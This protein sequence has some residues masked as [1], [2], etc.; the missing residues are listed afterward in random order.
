MSDRDEQRATFDVENSGGRR[1]LILRGSLVVAS[2]A[3]LWEPV[4]AA[5]REGDSIEVDAS[6]VDHCDGAGLALLAALSG[7]S[8]S[9]ELTGLSDSVARRLKLHDPDALAKPSES[10]KPDSIPVRVGKFTVQL[11]RSLAEQVEFVGRVV[12]VGTRSLLQ[13]A[14]IRWADVGIAAERA[15]ANAVP[16]VTIIGFLMG[17][18]MAFQSALPMQQFGVEIF[19]AD[20]V[21]IS[22]LK[23]LG[24]LMAAVVLAGRT[25]S[26]FAAELGTM[27]VNDEINALETMGVDPV[28]FLVIPRVL[29]A[30]LISPF[31]G[32]VC[33]AAGL[34]GGAVV[35]LSL[36]YPLATYADRVIA[37]VTLGAFLGG[38]VKS[39]AFG[40]LVAAV[41]CLRGLETGRDASA[42]GVSAT[43]AV[44]S[45]IVLIAV[46]DAVFAVVFYVLDI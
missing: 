16:I 36:G 32:L 12:A 7:A 24:P 10:S 8:D 31:L 29:G 5:A 14:K 40:V 1:R 19:V 17:L 9:V 43:R 22:M 28:R 33:S 4:V 13:P 21:A 23:E 45:G 26:A 39:V 15:G 2:V 46:S 3:S 18:I 37:T 38:V 27:T 35:L 30:V 34:F 44:V 42:V 41:G 6:A 11:G 25:G 20:L